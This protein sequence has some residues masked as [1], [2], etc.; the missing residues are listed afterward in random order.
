MLSPYSLDVAEVAWWSAYEIGQRVCDA[1]DDATTGGRAG[2]GPRV[3]IAGDACHTHSPKAG[4]G[5]NVSMAD[6]FNLGWKLAAVLQGRADPGL[7]DTYSVERRAKA[8][9]LIDFDRDMARLFSERSDDEAAAAEFQRYFQKHGRYTAGVE[10]RYEPSIITGRGRGQAL[11][12]GLVVGMRFHSAPVIRLA[13]A[14]PM[15]LGHVLKADGR[16]RLVL[17]APA[18]DGGASGGPIAETCR[19]LVDGR[20]GPIRRFTPDGAE[21]DAVIDVR[22]VFQSA[23]RQLALETMPP[24]LLPRKGRHGLIDYEKVFCPDLVRGPD[25]FDH[26]GIDRLRGAMIVVRPDQYVAEILAIDAVGELS[27]FF[28]G[29]MT[30]R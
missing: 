18:G 24:L 13:D 10:T 28:G 25:I 2:E 12:T 11:A 16:W 7:L 27:A 30:G 8:N 9:E 4:Q 14:L 5:M 19:R 15:H 23:H 22:A 29:F 3:F 6:S 20:D 21:V 1:F 17:F 26:R